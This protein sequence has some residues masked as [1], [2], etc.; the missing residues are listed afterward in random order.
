MSA[1]RAPDRGP[2]ATAPRSSSVRAPLRLPRPNHAAV[3]SAAVK[4]APAELPLKLG[5]R[6][7]EFHAK[8]LRLSREARLVPWVCI[9]CFLNESVG[10]SGAVSDGADGSL[11]DLALARSACHLRHG[12]G[13]PP[14]A[15]DGNHSPPIRPRV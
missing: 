1:V 2:G 10:V 12:K 3:A 11:E 13:G 4:E 15:A 9:V 5:L 7:E 14:T 6:L 8:A